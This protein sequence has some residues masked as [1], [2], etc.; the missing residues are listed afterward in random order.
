M[1]KNWQVKRWVTPIADLSSL[2]MVSLIDDG[3][4]NIT[5]EAPLL[6]NRPRWRFT[7]D[8]YPAYR[9]ILEEY[10]LG[11]WKHLDESHQR[12]GNTFIVKNSPWIASFQSQEPFLELYNPHLIHYVISTEDDVIEILAPSVEVTY[13]GNTDLYEPKAGKSIVFYNPTDREQIEK[14]FQEIVESQK[15]SKE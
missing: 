9:N 10:R 14:A 15:N 6:S 11:L 8:K 2:V 5:I 3:M 1:Y 12:C 7:F 13:L 4:L